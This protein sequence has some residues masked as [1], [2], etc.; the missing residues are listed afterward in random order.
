MSVLGRTSA[1][2][3]ELI[4]LIQVLQITAGVWVSIYTVSKYAFTAI[5]VHGALYK[6]KGLL[7]PEEKVLSMDRKFWN[8]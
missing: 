1:Q 3:A 6:E 7:S 2:K 5:H 8:C 4:P